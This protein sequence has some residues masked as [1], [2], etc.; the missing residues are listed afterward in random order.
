M[1]VRCK[2]CGTINTVDEN[3][4]YYICKECGSK[5]RV[6]IV[7]REIDEEF[8]SQNRERDREVVHVYHHSGSEDEEGSALVGFL[9]GFF[10]GVIGLIIAAIMG[11]KKT[12]KAAGITM[13]VQILL[14]GLIVGLVMCVG[15]ASMGGSSSSNYGY[16]IVNAINLF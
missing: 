14:I 15:L 6:P 7:H 4:D 10:L 12:I 2:E 1:K 3:E 11:Q 16:Y 9:L 8:E 13:L 5:L